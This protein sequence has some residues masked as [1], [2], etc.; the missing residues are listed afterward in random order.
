MLNFCFIFQLIGQYPPPPPVATGPGLDRPLYIPTPD[1]NSGEG[2]TMNRTR[3]FYQDQ[4]DSNVDVSGGAST[5]IFPDNPNPSGPPSNSTGGQGSNPVRGERRISGGNQSSNPGYTNTESPRRLD[6][7]Y[8]RHRRTSSNSS[9]STFTPAPPVEYAVNQEDL[10]QWGP[11]SISAGPEYSRK[12][13]RQSSYNSPTSLDLERPQTLEL[14]MT[15]RTPLRSSLRKNSNYS[16]HRYANMGGGSSGGTPTNPTPPDSLSEEVGP[17]GP[18]NP[19]GASR[20]DSGFVSTSNRV[21]FS[22][23]PFEKGGGNSSGVYV[24]DWSP[25][26][27]PPPPVPPAPHRTPKSPFPMQRHKRTSDSSMQPSSHHYITESDLQRD[28][29]LYPQS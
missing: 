12:Y 22:P 3:M 1:Y 4:L 8:G 23:S 25:T 9:N 15:P 13:S 14:P 24:T 19:I 28:F 18:G 20:S 17:G 5:F 10:I 16:N 2:Y 21:R 29:N 7:S 27:E 6:Q 26:H 11:G